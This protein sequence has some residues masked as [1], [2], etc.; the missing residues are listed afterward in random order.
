[1]APPTDHVITKVC[2][3]FETSAR[4]LLHVIPDPGKT[5]KPRPESGAGMMLLLLS[6]VWLHLV[7][8][9]LGYVG[10][11]EHVAGLLGKLPSQLGQAF[12]PLSGMSLG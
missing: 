9:V 5:N 3:G 4:F 1:M 7:I 8:C 12:H 10:P 6:Y 2:G 11:A